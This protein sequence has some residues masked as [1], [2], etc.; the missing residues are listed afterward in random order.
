MRVYF[1]PCKIGSAST[2][3]CSWPR[4]HISEY[5]VADEVIAENDRQQTIY[6]QPMTSNYP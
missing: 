1:K 6:R 3:R 2:C 4:G 5:E